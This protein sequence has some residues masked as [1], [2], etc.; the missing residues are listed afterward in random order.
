[1]SNLGQPV[2]VPSI[3]FSATRQRPTPDRPPKPPGKNW[4]KALE[5]RH[6]ELKARKVR[7]LD[8]NRH[9]KNTYEKITDWFKVIRKV[10][11]DPAGLVENMDEIGVILS[12]PG[13][14]KV[15]GQKESWALLHPSP[16]VSAQIRVRTSVEVVS[17]TSILHVLIRLSNKE[18]LAM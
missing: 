2:R 12:M 17:Q 6:P 9:E 3:A 5:N 14:V 16:F 7:A 10:L 1:M 8:W 13:S 18:G 15:L 4:A 11:Q